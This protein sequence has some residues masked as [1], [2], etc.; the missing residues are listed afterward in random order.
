[1]CFG[2][3]GVGAHVQ[4]APIGAVPERRPDL[5]AVDDEVVTVTHRPGA[6][7]GEIGSRFGLRHPLAPD[8][9]GAHHAGEQRFLLVF[10]AVLHD[11]RGDVVQSNDVERHRSPSA[12][13]LLGID[14]LLEDRRSAAAVVAGPGHRG[15]SRV[16]HRLVPGAQHF[17][18]RVVAAGG[19]AGGDKLIGQVRGQPV[20]QLGAELFH[21]RWIGEVHFSCSTV[22]YEPVALGFG[23][24]YLSIVGHR[25]DAASLT[26]FQ[27]L[28]DDRRGHQEVLRGG[29]LLEMRLDVFGCR[30]AF[31][32]RQPAFA[33]ADEHARIASGGG[34]IVPMGER[35]GAARE[36]CHQRHDEFGADRAHEAR[37]GEE[38]LVP[39][40]LGDHARE[41]SRH[42]RIG[43]YS[44]RFALD[45]DHVRQAH[46]AGFRRGVV[47]L[48]RLTEDPGGRGDEHEPSAAV[49]LHR[50]IRRL[51][52]V[53][54][55][56]EMYAQHSGPRVGRE[57]FERHAAEYA[58]VAD[59]G[60]QPP[61][62]V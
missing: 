56:V 55:A 12:G 47:S 10:G 28:V 16:R 41:T 14:Q 31:D 35:A 19:P 39:D 42:N 58:R 23:E 53:K 48:H 17:E 46:Q 27:H 54:A 26:H 18:R 34:G 57:V 5:L 33:Q 38:L 32:V 20:A 22:L 43:E 7:R 45:R 25:A 44:V 51:S 15:P 6:Q 62:R 8:V 59:D 37:F 49:L 40:G 61:E 24:C 60:V 29:H 30:L 36:E 2:S 21:F 50:A 1:M 9:V 52:Q 13:G 4:L 3:I 11:R